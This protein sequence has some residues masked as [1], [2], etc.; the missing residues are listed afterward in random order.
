M[1]FFFWGGRGSLL[2]FSHVVF[3]G[4]PIVFVVIFAVIMFASCVLAWQMHV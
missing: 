3:L 4:F 1:F 2:R